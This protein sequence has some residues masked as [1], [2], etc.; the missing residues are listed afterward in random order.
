[1]L[2]KIFLLALSAL[3]LCIGFTL[4]PT[5]A[6]PTVYVSS[7]GSDSGKGTVAEPFATLYTA[8]R[9]LPYGGKVVVCGPLNLAATELPESRGLITV[10]SVGDEDYRLSGGTGDAVIYLSGNITI[11]SAVK[12]E[13]LDINATTTNLVFICHGNY[14]CFG[15]NLNITRAND[16]I[17]F[18]GIVAGSTGAT[19]SNGSFIEIYSGNWFRVRGGARGT[20]SAP[21]EGGV[22]LAIHG[23]T[24]S[25]TFDMGGDSATNC[26]C[27]LLIYDGY[28]TSSINGATHA[29]AKTTG[30]I[31]LS[32]YGGTFG[33]GIR[34]SRGGAIEGDVTIN[35]FAN[36]AKTTSTDANAEISGEMT[37][38]L[39]AGVTA[40]ASD[41]FTVR[42]LSSAEAEEIRAQDTKMLEDARAA[43][44]PTVEFAAL[45]RDF[46]PSGTTAK[47]TTA[48]ATSSVG[49]VNGD[50][51]ISLADILAALRCISA[52]TY[53]AKADVDA[54]STVTL[55][56]V[57][58][59]TNLTLHGTRGF[60][61]IVSQN[62]LD[63]TM[64]LY[65]GAAA[66]DGKITR[67]AAFGTSSLTSY[68]LLSNCTMQ[69]GAHVSLYF[70]CDTVSATQMNGYCFDVDR[71]DNSVTLFAVA[72]GSYRTVATRK[73]MMYGDDAQL[74]AVVDQNEDDTSAVSLYYS[75]NQF[76]PEPYFVFNLNLAAKGNL[77]GVYAEN[78][79]VTLPVLSAHTASTAKTYTNTCLQEFT[80]P[81]IYYENGRY[82]V[83]GTANSTANNGV[84][85]YS[86]TNFRVFRDEGLAY[87][88][89]DG[90]GDGIFKAANVVKYGD[91][92]Y[93]FYM[94]KSTEL[95]VTGVTAYASATA[96][97]GP[98]TN[99]DKRPLA[100]LTVIGGQPF[101]DAD[102]Q[103]Y[104]IYTRITGGNKLYGAKITLDGGVA[105]LDMSTETQL[106]TATEPWENAKASVVECGYII[107]HGDT[108]YLMYS[109]GNYDSTYGTGF[110]T[111]KNPLGPYT[112]YAF[113]PILVSNDQAFGV[114]AASVFASP[115]G[116][117]HFIIYLRNFSPTQSRPLCT[118]IDRI[119]FVKNPSG[120]DDILAIQ[121][122]SVTPQPLPANRTNATE[123]PDYQK[124]RFIW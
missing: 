80:D 55:L 79:S 118:C 66:S 10:T 70:G 52:K 89:G 36:I 97:T 94:A 8:F 95:G 112:K 113:N 25:G 117:E 105:T 108:Y 61:P 91:Y 71:A 58:R 124:Y 63:D 100:D 24:F 60:A 109:G 77:C 86:T 13:N 116:S 115:D 99:T 75:D 31:Y 83:F 103:V 85:C 11:K 50:G 74:L 3:L 17:N 82:Y 76:D 65:G 32:V 45:N 123:F 34:A 53:D 9:A 23:G 43:R 92:Y 35:V 78:A 96:L 73:I 21:Q 1:M 29:D 121:G 51:R 98:Y 57:L 114:G 42:T 72:D 2:K 30:N 47:L 110:A 81:E 67:G 87:T 14:V 22:L 7:A 93:M 68:A 18:P 19:S 119:K 6:E 56:D 69:A 120:G 15:E 59:L 33:T 101:V 4:L 104:L 12:F 111:A 88:K 107:R 16:Q 38:N 28:F 84:K 90:F 54:S 41:A 62:A 27:A 44:I 102:G 64:T 106:L 49:D 122:P 20:S 39:A 48:T 5:A 37:F 40:K 46:T 26:D